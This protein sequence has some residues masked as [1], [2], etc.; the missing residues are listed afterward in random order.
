[1]TANIDHQTLLSYRS[2]SV[3]EPLCRVI[4]LDSLCKLMTDRQSIDQNIKIQSQSTVF[5]ASPTNLV[6]NEH[7]A[8]SIKNSKFK[9]MSAPKLKS[10]Q[11]PAVAYASE[12]YYASE[13]I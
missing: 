4:E 6:E 5:E 10:N 12:Q 7:Q 13:L 1:M 3:D 9:F 11:H 2:I 8:R